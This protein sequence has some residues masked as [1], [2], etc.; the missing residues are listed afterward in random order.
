MA[1]TK[2]KKDQ[3]FDSIEHENLYNWLKELG[4]N[5]E[6]NPKLGEGIYSTTISGDFIVFDIFPKGLVVEL[7]QQDNTGT[8]DEKIPYLIL[9]I[10]HNY[11]LPTVLILQGTGWRDGCFEWAKSQV[12]GDLL[13]VFPDINSFK[14]WMS[15]Y[16]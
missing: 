12:G 15:G 1:K 2:T 5:V 9:N 10:K 4:C 11:L 8:T 13:H 14:G 16:K 6:V 3:R 7:K